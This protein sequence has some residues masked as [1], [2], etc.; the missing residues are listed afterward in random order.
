MKCPEC[1]HED[2]PGTQAAL[3]ALI[4]S[5]KMG[6]NEWFG[7]FEYYHQAC[8][9]ARRIPPSST[10]PYAMPRVRRIFRNYSYKTPRYV[11]NV[12]RDIFRPTA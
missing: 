12:T 10:D 2:C 1:G 7:D 8:D 3:E 6:T 5:G 9:A 4:T 11:W